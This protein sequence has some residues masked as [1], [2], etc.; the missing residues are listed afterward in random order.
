MLDGRKNLVER[1]RNGDGSAGDDEDSGV[2]QLVA[3]G[4]HLDGPEPD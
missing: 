4:K 3:I 2:M 1:P